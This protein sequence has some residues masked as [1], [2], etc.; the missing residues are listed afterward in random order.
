MYFLLL[1]VFTPDFWFKTDLDCWKYWSYYTDKEG[2]DQVYHCGTNYP[3][4][5]LYI[6]RFFDVIMGGHESAL[7]HYTRI[8][9]ITLIFDFL[10]VF[11]LFFAGMK[12]LLHRNYHWFLLF[13]A[14]Y[15]FNTLAWGQVDAIH[16]NLCLLSL[17]LA[18]RYPATSV[19][20]FVIALNTKLQSIIFFPLLGVMLIPHLKEV[21]PAL[22]IIVSAVVT[23]ILVVLPFIIAGEFKN[24][25]EVMVDSVDYFKVASMNAYN[26]WHLILSVDPITVA[27]Q[28]KFLVFTYKQWGLF[29]FCLSSS[30]VLGPLLIKT[31]KSGLGYLTSIEGK[32]LV[33]LSAAVISLSFF[34]FNTQMHERY[35]HPAM[36]FL[37]FYAAFSKQFGP[38]ILVSIA[39]LLNMERILL[40]FTVP[41]HTVI[42]SPEFSAALFLAGLLWLYFR[43]YRDG[44]WK[45]LFKFSL[46]S[47]PVAD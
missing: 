3:P 14:A 42:F 18:W 31:L 34:F 21:K 16:S 39:Y 20:V 23:E 45:N 15:L 12:E 9:W 7:L 4:V 38:Y 37:F 46:K 33:M 41:H 32:K 40:Y 29:L 11:I 28:E 25:Y 47:T 27:D 2:M 30:L 35:S 26:F 1:M 5:Y 19:A 43:I 8:K 17:F 36:I 6:L 24:Y 22:R 13:N 10:P 44:I